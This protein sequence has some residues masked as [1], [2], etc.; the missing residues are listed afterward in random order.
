MD[1]SVSRSFSASVSTSSDTDVAAGTAARGS[2]SLPFREALR[3]L[4][5]GVLYGLLDDGLFTSSSARKPFRVAGM[6]CARS[7]MFGA[8]VVGAGAARAI[9]Q[10][11]RG[12]RLG[13]GRSLTGPC[14]CAVIMASN[15]RISDLM[16]FYISAFS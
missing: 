13:R 14:V 11:F 5:G 1:S 7:I 12:L 8:D 10:V 6:F 16:S 2:L 3:G 9:L 4:A 15:L